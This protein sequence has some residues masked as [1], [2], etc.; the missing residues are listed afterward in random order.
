VYN[1][2]GPDG[3]LLP[4][5]APACFR[6]D[7]DTAG[8]P[9]IDFS[10]PQAVAVSLSNAAYMPADIRFLALPDDGVRAVAAHR[11][12]APSA[13]LLLPSTGAAAPH[14]RVHHGRGRVGCRRKRPRRRRR[15]RAPSAARRDARE[16]RALRIHTDYRLPEPPGRQRHGPA[17]RLRMPPISPRGA[18]DHT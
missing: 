8:A 6:R 14:P 13:P 9:A 2:F 16:R 5:Y 7:R 15:D 4:G 3:N 18:A 10:C 11:V 17:R 12:L 1:H